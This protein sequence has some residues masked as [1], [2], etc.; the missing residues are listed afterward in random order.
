M[1]VVHHVPRPA[2]VAGVD[3]FGS[4]DRYRAWWMT[5]PQDARL[6]LAA[7]RHPAS[8]AVGTLHY[9]QHRL[10]DVVRSFVALMSRA[11]DPGAHL[12]PAPVGRNRWPRGHQARGVSGWLVPVAVEDPFQLWIDRSGRWWMVR[13][14][15]DAALDA[16]TIGTPLKRAAELDQYASALE[17]VLDSCGI[18]L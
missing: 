5:S 6:H 8:R 9:S 2:D 7:Q 14:D 3:R 4:L 12:L 15:G 16:H 13:F 11:G 18:A 1:F 10:D 17:R